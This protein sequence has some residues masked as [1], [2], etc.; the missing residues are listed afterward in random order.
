MGFD[1]EIYCE[2]YNEADSS[3]VHHFREYRPSSNGAFI[4]HHSY[5]TQILPFLNKISLPGILIFHNMTPSSFVKPYNVKMAAALEQ[6]RE[7]LSGM[8]Q[9]FASILC[10]SRFN[11]QELHAL[12]FQGGSVMPV[13]MRS[14]DSLNHELQAK[15]DN[16]R[17]KKGVN[18][19]FVGRIFPNKRHQD[20]IKAFYFFKELC[21]DSRMLFV[22]AFH[23][24]MKG[25]TAEL[26]N[27]IQALKLE[28]DIFFTGM[29]SDDELLAY[30]ANAHLFL[31]MSEH[32]GFFVPLVESMSYQVPIMAYASSVIPET[33]G[34]SGVLIYE[35]DFPTIA[36]WMDTIIKDEALRKSIVDRQNERAKEFRP[37]IGLAAFTKALQDVGVAI[38]SKK[39][40]DLLLS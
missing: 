29:I 30:Y 39:V 5:A 40:N 26:Y 13:I 3:L 19:L 27:L 33:M 6:T 36:R 4:Y 22:G 12:G 18:I 23:P 21:P 31:S 16:G 35:K 10:D 37:S 38:D 11:L 34:E 25:Y 9:R 14:P 20:L 17:E 32:E 24:G 7:I 8:N 2:N 1:S 28:K 15:A